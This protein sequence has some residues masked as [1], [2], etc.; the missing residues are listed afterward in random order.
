MLKLQIQRLVSLPW[1]LKVE[2]ARLKI[3]NVIPPD[4]GII[5]FCLEGNVLA[6]RDL[7][8]HGMA[9]S[10]DITEDGETPLMVSRL[11]LSM[12]LECLIDDMLSK[13]TISGRHLDL[14]RDLIERYSADV[15][16]SS[17]EWDM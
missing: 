13:S 16:V 12:I 4:S 6:V 11:S 1:I 2:N 7:L 3:R 14:V 8:D 10:N 9:G 15:D 17:G 5:K